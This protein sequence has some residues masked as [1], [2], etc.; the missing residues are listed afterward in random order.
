MRCEKSSKNTEMQ[1]T[2]AGPKWLAE[3][4][5]HIARRWG[6]SYFG[7]HDMVRRV[8][9][10]GEAFNLVQKVLGLCATKNG[11]KIDEPM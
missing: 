7:G 3:D 2:C 5:K 4:S 10:Q 11:T 8:V 6:K 1:G 9:G